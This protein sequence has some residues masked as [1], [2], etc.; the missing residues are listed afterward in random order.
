MLSEFRYIA[1][2]CGMPHSAPSNVVKWRRGKG[3]WDGVAHYSLFNHKLGLISEWYAAHSSQCNTVSFSANPQKTHIKR[4]VWACVFLY[5]CVYVCT[6]VCVR[7]CARMSVHAYACVCVC[8]CAC[9]ACICVCA[10]VCVYVHMHALSVCV[11]VRVCLWVYVCV[12]VC[13]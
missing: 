4:C 3:L 6:Y 5:V 12:C 11:C 2:K 9:T 10:S 8:V 7:L 13:F 1:F